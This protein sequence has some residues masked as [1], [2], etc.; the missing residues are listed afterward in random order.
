MWRRPV[1]NEVSDISHAVAWATELASAAGLD[2]DSR[3]GIE[4][5]L[6]EALANL[7][8]HAIPEGTTKDIAI[9]FTVDSIGAT[10]II[11]DRCEPFDLTREAVPALPSQEE[12]RVGGQGLRLL[13]RFSNSLSYHRVGDE[14]QLTMTFRRAAVPGDPVP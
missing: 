8:L 6:E 12:M 9:S 4:L 5:C 1:E 7:V 13:R 11:S 2:E 14:N 10:I 3:F